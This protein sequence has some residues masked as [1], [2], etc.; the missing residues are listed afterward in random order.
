MS[1]VPEIAAFDI[2][3]WFTAEKLNDWT[4]LLIRPGALKADQKA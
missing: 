3:L 1:D 2:S 4:L